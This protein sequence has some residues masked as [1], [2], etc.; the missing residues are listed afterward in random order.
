MQLM[1]SFAQETP[2]HT[3]PQPNVWLRLHNEQRQ[4]A[5]AVLARLIAKAAA[6]SAATDSNKQRKEAHDD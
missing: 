1:L 4:E 2:N 3:E 6:A 5:L